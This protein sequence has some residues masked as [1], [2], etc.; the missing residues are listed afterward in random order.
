MGLS[1]EIRRRLPNLDRTPLTSGET[2]GDLIR[3]AISLYNHQ[4]NGWDPERHLDID[5]TVIEDASLYD[6]KRGERNPEMI[7]HNVVETLVPHLF[8]EE[9]NSPAEAIDEKDIKD[10]KSLASS[11]YGQKRPYQEIFVNKLLRKLNT[12]DRITESARRELSTYILEKT[13]VYNLSNSELRLRRRHIIEEGINHFIT[14]IEEPETAQEMSITLPVT[15]DP[16][17]YNLEEQIDRDKIAHNTVEV[18]AENLF[19]FDKQTWKYGPII[20]KDE[21]EQIIDLKNNDDDAS[22]IKDVF[23]NK[24][25][26]KLYRTDKITEEA[27]A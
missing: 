17:L 5:I 23:I 4:I 2:R 8:D 14:R 1:S 3:E 25:L 13:P 10:I 21:I 11:K 12:S 16:K 22:D 7:A 24:L 19:V 27:R 15:A 18:V 9:N 6:I 20:K 26:N